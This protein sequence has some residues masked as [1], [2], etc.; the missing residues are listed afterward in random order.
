MALSS[1]QCITTYQCTIFDFQLLRLL[2]FPF[3]SLLFIHFYLPFFISRCQYL[4]KIKLGFLPTQM[5]LPMWISLLHRAMSWASTGLPATTFRFFSIQAA[6]RLLRRPFLLTPVGN[7]CTRLPTWLSFF[8]STWPN[9]LNLFSP[10]FI[11]ISKEEIQKVEYFLCL[12]L[13][14]VFPFGKLFYEQD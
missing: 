13:H 10:S 2:D 7:P 12:F 4:Y 5:G 8:F 3:L 1:Y 9:H 11:A 6:Y 14:F